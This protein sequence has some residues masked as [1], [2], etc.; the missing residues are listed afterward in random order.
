MFEDGGEEH[1]ARVVGKQN[2]RQHLI[3]T[4]LGREYTIELNTEGKS[5]GLD[6][7]VQ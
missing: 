5:G 2:R 4:S 1:S 6:F 3:E 7:H